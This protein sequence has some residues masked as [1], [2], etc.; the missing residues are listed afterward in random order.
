MSF[1]VIRLY[2][3]L[4]SSLRDDSC[5]RRRP[6]RGDLGTSRRHKKLAAP[7]TCAPFAAN[8]PAEIHFGHLTPREG[9]KGEE[10]SEVLT[11]H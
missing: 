7:E 8:N 9:T 4:S 5:S 3:R 11:L 6:K 10:G 2:L 1:P